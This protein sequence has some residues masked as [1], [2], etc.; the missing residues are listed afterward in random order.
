[1]DKTRPLW[2]A[3]SLRLVATAVPDHRLRPTV[4]LAAFRTAGWSLQ[5]LS[6]PLPFKASSD[7]CFTFG[8]FLAQMPVS[9]VGA[10]MFRIGEVDVANAGTSG[11]AGV[12]PN[13]SGL[14]INDAPRSAAE[15]E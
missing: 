11:I 1:M 8:V 10:C 13:C 6:C 3:A 14:M 2:E 7:N 12:S 5:G 9:V 4:V 15:P